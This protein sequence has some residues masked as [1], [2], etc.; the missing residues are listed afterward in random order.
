MGKQEITI[1]DFH[2]PAS[3]F[4][5]S[6]EG[7]EPMVRCSFP[8]DGYSDHRVLGLRGCGCGNK[9]NMK[10][11]PCPQAGQ[12]DWCDYFGDIET[13]FTYRAVGTPCAFKP[14]ETA[15]MLKYYAEVKKDRAPEALQKSCNAWKQG[16]DGSAA[17]NEVVVDAAQWRKDGRAQ[18]VAMVV[19]SSCFKSII[20]K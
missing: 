15:K 8:C 14:T 19:P 7:L 13:N 9:E 12:A 4:I 5:A 1:F 18:I 10:D 2:G 11:F 16:A 20:C 3:G 6:A 17:W